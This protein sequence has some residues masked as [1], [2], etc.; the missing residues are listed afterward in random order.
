MPATESRPRPVPRITHDS[1]EFW[2][3]ATQGKLLLR[4]CRKCENVFY[5]PRLLC[6]RCLSEDLDSR[7]A[8]GSGTVHAF[9]IVYR[10]PDV[11]FRDSVPY[12]VAIIE[13][14]EGPRMLSNVT[15]CDVDTVRVGMPV[16]LWF[17]SVSSEISLP[18]FRPSL[19]GNTSKTESIG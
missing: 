6:P 18:K 7:A 16:E 11:S 15:H 1:Q 17:D 2:R 3:F 4:V 19:P 12:V 8:A 14:A 13:L 10:A 9:S 5:Y